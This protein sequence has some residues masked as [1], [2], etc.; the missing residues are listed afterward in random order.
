M[1][2]LFEGQ[3]LAESKRLGW[4]TV[5]AILATALG[6]RVLLQGVVA[7]QRPEVSWAVDVLFYGLGAALIAW[8]SLYWISR[9]LQ[10]QP[11]ESE[12]LAT[13]VRNFPDAII[14]LDEGWTIQT[15]NRGAQLLFGYRSRE[16]VGSP[17]QQLLA[18]DAGAETEPADTQKLFAE[19]SHFQGSELLMLTKD[20]E[21]IVT[22]TTGSLL[23]DD[24]TESR[25]V[26]LILRDVTEA[27]HAQENLRSLYEEAEAKMRERTRKLE[28]ARHELEMRNAELHRA[29]QELQALDRLKSDFVS[30]VSHELRSPLTNI[31]GAIELML[32]EEELSDEYIRKMLGVMGEQSERLIRLV[33]GV[34]DI[35]RIQAGRLQLDRQELDLLHIMQRVVE[36][37]QAASVFHWFEL[38]PVDSCPPV[39][40]D[41]DRIEE[42]FLNLLDNAIKFSPSGGPITIG[43]EVGDTEATISIADPGIGI[44]EA[45]L[46]KIFQKFHRLD[47]EDSRVTYGHGLGLYITKALVEAHGGRIWVESAEGEG[48]TFSFT[49]P[50]A[51]H[52][53]TGSQEDVPATATQEVDRR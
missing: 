27:Q 34:L 40:G 8:L 12:D 2:S 18:P 26:V 25:G 6:Y 24:G 20:G 17:F 37:L 43:L 49:L 3:L 46:D 23:A 16:M 13:A 5:V 29:Y 7:R 35:S 45:E 15:W 36:S 22:Q 47:R 11:R 39:W 32:E 52:A 42:A 41:E 9:R 14:T 1:K 50:L 30:M 28:L 19:R 51:A 48:S 53:T 4:L 10:N 33:K 44:P 31:T 21:R 38:P